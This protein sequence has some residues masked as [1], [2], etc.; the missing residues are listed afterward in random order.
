MRAIRAL[1][2]RGILLGTVESAAL[3]ALYAAAMPDARTERFYGPKGPGHLGGPP[4]EQ[5]LYG[6]LRNED[7]ARRVWD[8]S[9]ELTGLTI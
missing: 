4:A 8:V 5:K 3:P 9:L 7:E 6:R 2:S 1:S